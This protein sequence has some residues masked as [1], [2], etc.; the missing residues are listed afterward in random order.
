[1][2]IDLVQDGKEGEVKIEDVNWAFSPKVLVL[3]RPKMNYLPTL[4]CHVLMYGTYVW[5]TTL[6]SHAIQRHLAR[7]YIVSALIIDFIWI[8]SS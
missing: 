2:P 6:V 5:P 8:E 7:H 3:V 1:M 4:F